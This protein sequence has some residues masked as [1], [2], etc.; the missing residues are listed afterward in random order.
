MNH[1]LVWL[2]LSNIF[3]DCQILQVLPFGKEGIYVITCR[4]SWYG[5]TNFVCGRMLFK[6]FIIEGFETVFLKVIQSLNRSREAPA[7]EIVV[8]DLFLALL[9]NKLH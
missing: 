3:G 2:N 1:K 8:E 6:I 5:Q 9:R 4:Q 7:Q